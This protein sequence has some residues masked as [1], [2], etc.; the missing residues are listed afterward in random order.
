MKRELARIYLKR[1]DPEETLLI[2]Q[3]ELGS[4]QG[5]VM[6]ILAKAYEALV[7]YDGAEAMFVKAKNRYPETVTYAAE[8]AGFL[9]R[10]GRYSDAAKELKRGRQYAGPHSQ[11]YLSALHE[12]LHLKPRETILAT[13]DNWVEEGAP[14]HQVASLAYAFSNH[15][16]HEMAMAVLSR[17][18][19]KKKMMILENQADIYKILRQWK[20]PDA[21]AQ[22][23][24]P[25][26][27]PTLD[28]P[29]SMVLF[30]EGMFD[31]IVAHVKDL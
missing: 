26:L 13:V 24:R 25:Y 18:T 5:G 3:D 16:D 20:G 4:Y 31:I 30:K 23:I 21:A 15:G 19:P 22:A 8:Y 27:E 2:L 9:L 7:Q 10:R 29:F 1:G 11:W 6:L 28:G 17:A 14:Q 12:S